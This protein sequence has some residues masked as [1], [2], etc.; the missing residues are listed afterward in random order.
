[1]QAS[2]TF[3]FVAIGSD[4]SQAVFSVDQNGTITYN[5]NLVHNAVTAGGA[6]VNA[7]SSDSTR[8]TIEDTGA[9]QLVGGAAAVR[10]DPT[11]AA[12]IDASSSYRV[13]VTPNGDTHGLFVAA[14]TPTGFIVREA[15]GGRSTVTF[16]YRII[17]TAAGKTGQRMSFVAKSSI[18][19]I[20]RSATQPAMPIPP[21]P[22]AQE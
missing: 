12:A 10:L 1:M 19:P 17:A 22:P 18:G 8:P 3:P 11:F 15:E 16:D 9:A 7:F 21:A 13:F 2:A 14:K 4:G 5:G 6:M 20:L